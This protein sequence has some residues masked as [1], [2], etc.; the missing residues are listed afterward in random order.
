MVVTFSDEVMKAMGFRQ[1]APGEVVKARFSNLAVFAVEGITVASTGIETVTIKGH[2]CKLAIAP[3]VNEA[4]QA[5]LSDN[6]AADEAEWQNDHKCSGPYA[7]VAI[8]PTDE[9]EADSGL[10]KQ[11]A[12]GSIT[13]YDCFRAARAFLKEVGNDVLPALLTA[14]TCNFF[15]PGRHFRVRPVDSASFGTTPAGLTVHDFRITGSGH[16]FAPTAASAE[17]VHEGLAAVAA[18]APKLNVKVA[19]FFKLAMFEKDDLKRFLYFFLAL[20][21]KTHATFALIDHLERLGSLVPTT[22]FS[23]Q[24][25]VALL[26]RHT[27]NMKNLRDR[28]VWC[29]FCAWTSITDDDVIEFKRLKDIRDAIAHGSIDVPPSEA[30]SSIQALTI[31]VLRH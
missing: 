17:T 13:T 26:Q 28:F 18:Q 25:A 14:L 24:S 15:T 2:I 29:A 31:K 7:L 3:T 1:F 23:G 22:S 27:D 21:V 10:I 9:Y 12:D 20:E 6:Y 11:E 19:R 16:G 5:L 8:G 30:V 4:C